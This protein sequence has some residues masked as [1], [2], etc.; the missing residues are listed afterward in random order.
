MTFSQMHERLRV[1][2]LRR[3]QRGTLS[4]SLLSR[5]TGFGK[6]H[7]SNFLHSRRQLSIEGMDR[8]MAA[9]S[10]AAEDL[11]PEDERHIHLGEERDLDS[12]PVV[13]HMTALFEPHIRASAIQM[14]LNVPARTLQSLKSRP[15][16]EPPR[17]GAVCR[18]SH[19]SCRRATH[20]A[21][22]VS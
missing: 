20:G 2:M 15:V 8:I 3:I 13:S 17:M 14:M 10:M 12:V 9:Q 19:S 5:Q 6:S 4:I 7:L 16:G 1:E 21:T 18:D 22:A 11:L